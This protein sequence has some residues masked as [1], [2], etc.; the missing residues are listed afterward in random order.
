MNYSFTASSVSPYWRASFFIVALSVPAAHAGCHV[1]RTQRVKFMLPDITLSAS[2]PP[3][4]ILAQKTITLSG[5]SD[6][7]P[8]ICSGDGR[9]TGLARYSSKNAHGIYSTNVRG[10]GY[11]LLMDDKHF[12][13]RAPLSCKGFNCHHAWPVKPK[14]TFQLVQ[15]LPAVEMSGVLHPGV[16]GVI[17]PDSGKPAVLISLMHGVHLRQESCIVQ[18]EKVD[19]G[20]VDF[21][22]NAFRGT[23]ISSKPFALRYQCAFQGPIL[24]RWEG[25]ATDKGYLSSPQLKDKGIAIRISHSQGSPLYLNRIFKVAPQTGALMFKAD[26]ISDGELSQGN[27]NATATFH[28]IYP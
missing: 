7:Q 8:F 24:T 6:E 18:D 14:I 4:S 10:I 27:F 1:E 5:E 21:D 2:N 19:F 13:W 23:V 11:R 15:T 22:R 16:Y 20:E 3:G 28:I 12:P 25:V 17:Q 9:V 26:L